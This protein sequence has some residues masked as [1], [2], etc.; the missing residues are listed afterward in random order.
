MDIV[1][2]SIKVRVVSCIL[3]STGSALIYSR[4]CDKDAGWLYELP[5]ILIILGFSLLV[6][7]KT[8]RKVAIIIALI[9][10]IIGLLMQYT[11]QYIIH[12]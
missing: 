9:F 7:D 10:S 8:T 2:K 6:Y 5:I 4:L 12:Q 11:L 1:N 3:C